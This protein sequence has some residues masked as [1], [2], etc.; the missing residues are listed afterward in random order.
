MPCL[1]EMP[2]DTL[3]Y[4]VKFVPEKDHLPM[5]LVSRLLAIVCIA[6]NTDRGLRP[7]RWLTSAT[8]TLARAEW[9]IAWNALPASAWSSLR[10]TAAP[11]TRVRVTTMS[12]ASRL[13]CGAR[14][15][16]APTFSTLSALHRVRPSA[17]TARRSTG[18]MSPRGAGGLSEED[19][20]RRR[21]NHY[22]RTEGWA[23][24][25]LRHRGTVEGS[26][27]CKNVG[28]LVTR[29]LTTGARSIRV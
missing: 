22:V 29:R 20:H 1:V 19:R 2:R 3:E 26:Y 28:A 24:V 6:F 12:R 16:I 21:D 27:V 8:S 7:R 23:Y 11:T 25:A 18:R 17:S 4:L 14:R 9:A 13:L 15:T 10:A 5:A